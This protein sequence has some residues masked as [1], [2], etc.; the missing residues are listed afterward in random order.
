VRVSSAA[1]DS[2]IARS[3][4]RQG[5]R[6]RVGRLRSGEA[7]WAKLSEEEKQEL[8]TAGGKAR[9]EQ[10]TAT[11]RKKIAKAAAKARWSKPKG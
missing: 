6:S 1:Y 3:E 7:R 2:R 8:R 9:A 4:A 10:I 5:L 11:Q